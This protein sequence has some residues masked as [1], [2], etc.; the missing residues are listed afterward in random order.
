MRKVL[1]VFA[2][3]LLPLVADAVTFG[4]EVAASAPRYS[5]A[6]GGQN[7]ASLACGGESCV[8]LWI[9][10]HYGRAGLYSSVISADGTVSPPSSNLLQ[11]GLINSA[12]IVWAGDHY[13]ATWGN[14]AK[15]YS[16]PLGADGRFAG[17]VRTITSNAS[18]GLPSTRSLAWNGRQ[19][20][21]VFQ[22]STGVV[23]ALLD[24]TGAL[25]RMLRLPVSNTSV[26][27]SA[28]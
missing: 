13:L 25:V 22:T 20:L 12:S 8:A 21:E 7:E 15:L 6:F 16:A 5:E 19:A 1:V 4:R 24:A 2:A 10:V 23:A 28:A 9:E 27:Y 11:S 3:V 17:E 14:G 18:F 26:A